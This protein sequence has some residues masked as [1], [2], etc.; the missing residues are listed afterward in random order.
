L[1]E[2]SNAIQVNITTLKKRLLS[3]VEMSLLPSV[4][5]STTL[6]NRPNLLHLIVFV[7]TIFTYSILPI[8]SDSLEETTIYE[9]ILQEPYYDS[10]I[11]LGEKLGTIK[12]Q[13]SNEL[14]KKL[15]ENPYH[16]NREAAVAGILVGNE[17]EFI[18]IL[19]KQFLTDPILRSRIRKG[20]VSNIHLYIKELIQIYEK[21]TNP[22]NR[23]LLI[24]LIAISPDSEEY[25][26][27]K[28]EHPIENK[29]ENL[30]QLP[31][32]SNGGKEGN[33]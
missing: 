29:P 24:S 4:V 15:L 26:K 8:Q 11:Q 22:S 19:I 1:P 33:N 14:L 2:S 9:S 13:A 7:F 25:F 10:K 23:D 31:N 6:C 21:E 5:T 3:G 18:E 28:M 12:T 17:K 27:K 32:N 20:I 16:W 30:Q